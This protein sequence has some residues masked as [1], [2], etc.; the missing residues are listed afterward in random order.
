M[1]LNASGWDPLQGRVWS[2]F[3][4]GLR[5][6][7]WPEWPGTPPPPSRGHCLFWAGLNLR[8]QVALEKALQ[9]QGVKQ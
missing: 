5:G 1:A 6:P 9:E 7:A 4:V 2:L 3:L 8:P